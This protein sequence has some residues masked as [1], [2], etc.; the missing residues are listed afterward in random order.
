MELAHDLGVVSSRCG[1][2]HSFPDE[3]V[4]SRLREK[5]ASSNDPVK[6]RELAEHDALIAR[7]ATIH[8]DASGSREV[9][10]CHNCDNEWYF[11]EHGYECPRCKSD[12]TEIVSFSSWT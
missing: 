9:V 3:Q 12:L 11:D 6:Q 5:A 1:G 10:Y 2:P 7:A 4:L 8:L